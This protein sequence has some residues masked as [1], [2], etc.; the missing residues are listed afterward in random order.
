MQKRKVI[1]VGGGLAG[2]S[3]AYELS[4]A[5]GFEIHVIE[6]E[7]RLGGRVHGCTI[8]GQVV[9]VGGFLIYPW[10]KR[11]RQLINELNLEEELVRVPEARDYY[12]GHEKM[13]DEYEKGFN[14]SYKDLL[15][16]FIR[17]FPNPLT[18]SD[19]TEPELD[20][21]G[22]LTIEDYIKSLDL[23]AE[24][25]SLYLRVFDTYL[26][27]YCYGPANKHKMAFMAATLFQNGFH[28]DV[29]SASY[30]R[31]GSQVFIDAMQAELERRNVQ[32]HLN[33]TLES[34]GD[35]QFTTNQEVI[36]ADDFVF[37]H[38]PADIPYTGFITA[39][40]SYSGVAQVE[41]D[42]EWGS[43]FYKEN[44]RQPFSVLS[45]V[46]LEKLY[47]H[48]VKGHINLN[49]KAN[50][51]QAISSTDLM[52]VIK[53]ELQVKFKDIAV[54]D[55][56]N[57]VDWEGAM[58]IAE[59]HYVDSIRVKQGLNNCYFGG[60]FMGCPSMETALMTG[61]RAAEQLIKDVQA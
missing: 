2:L 35:K 58:P 7:S 48:K 4:A 3:A 53:S 25:T 17:V 59:E 6:K 11:Y 61:K 33:C 23:D 12:A 1:I 13:H 34:M 36:T 15:E 41:G 24:K 56:V 29:H 40:V 55:L 52:A 14:F 46:N 20:A 44:A 9:D 28:G 10:Y 21:Y 45:I 26:Q 27:G 50:Q 47:G 22:G 16:I 18:D 19:P 49:I 57:R 43:C 37:C 30:L 39:T 38:T 32:I 8:N 5:E 54:L 51:P 31:N 60:D 42:T